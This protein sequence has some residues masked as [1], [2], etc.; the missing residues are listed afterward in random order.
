MSDG[1]GGGRVGMWWSWRGRSGYVM[2][3][4]GEE[5]VCSGVGGAGVGM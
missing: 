4:E 3:L 2:E 1:V 5:W